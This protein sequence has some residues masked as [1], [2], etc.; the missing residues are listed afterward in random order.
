MTATGEPIYLAPIKIEFDEQLETLQTTRKHCKTWRIGSE[1]ITVKLTPTNGELYDVMVSFLR[2]EHREGVRSTRCVVPGVKG[3][4]RCDDNNS[5]K[6]CPYGRNP[7]DKL[8]FQI[9]LD[10][11]TSTGYEPGAS[12]ATLSQALFEI[13]LEE[14]R[15][16]MSAADPR[17]LVVFDM[18]KSKKKVSD[19]M[20]ELNVSQTRA[21][22]L[23]AR[24]KQIV[25]NHLYS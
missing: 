20:A 7:D 14:A 25:K 10:E 23:I 6:N 15:N 4:I 22:Q 12:D 19:I 1:K 11:L 13:A 3:T 17:L 18:L 8:Y 5:C 16:E 2:S 9:S 24:T 21:Y